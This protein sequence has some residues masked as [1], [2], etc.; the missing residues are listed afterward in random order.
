MKNKEVLF[1]MFKIYGNPHIDWMGFE[2]TKRNFIT[3][4]HI[5][6]ER[7]GGKETV[8]NGALLTKSSHQKLH[9]LERNNPEL[10]NEYQYWFKIMNEMECPPTD[11]IMAIIYSLKNRLKKALEV[12][13]II[14]KSE[15]TYYH[16]SYKK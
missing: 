12:D 10:Y 7:I 2:V 14:K 8:Q 3:Y 15:K 16:S 13:R 1:E 11:E 6:E 4:H 9:K 5:K